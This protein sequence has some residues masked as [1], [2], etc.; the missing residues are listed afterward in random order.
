MKTVLIIEKLP[1]VRDNF[2]KLLSSQ[3]SLF[4]VAA[5][6]TVAE[7]IDLLEEIKVDVVI[8]GRQIDAGDV[9]LL[10]Q[11]MRQYPNSKLIVMADRKSQVASLLKAFEYKIQFETPVD[12]PLLLETLLSEFDIN[13]GGQLRGI[14][15]A[16]FL[17]MIELDDQTCRI[18]VL[19]GAKTGYLYCANGELIDAQLPPLAGKE[20]A[21]A[22]LGLENPLITVDYQTPDKK[23]T[24]HE[25]LMSLLLESGRLE[26]EQKPKQSERR[27][28]KRVSCALPVEFV[29][30]EWSYKAVISNISLSGIF[31]QTENPFSVG[32]EMDIAFYSQTLEKGCNIP[33]EVV[34]RATNGIG[35]ELKPMGI[36]Q[37]AILRTIIN[38]VTESRPK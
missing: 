31:I 27:R 17:Q 11:R 10:D 32:D 29:Y 18:K 2:I 4:N 22:I 37:M 3:I 16:S 25:P 38:E 19:S 9:A 30:K 23:R 33:G 35:I 28:Y 5:A 6:D 14:S 7:A 26:D 20:A 12:I 13:Y 15:I 36:N 21:F 1:H 24:I 8:T 34:R